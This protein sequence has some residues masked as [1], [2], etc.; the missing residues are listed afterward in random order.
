MWMTEGEI[1]RSFKFAKDQYYQ[2]TILS[3]LNATT[4]KEIKKILIANGFEIPTRKLKGV[5]LHNHDYTEKDCETIRE[6]RSNHK[7]WEQIAN[8]LGVKCS[9]SVRGF[10][11]RHG[12]I[13]VEETA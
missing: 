3:Q 10:A 5:K 2:I 6:M 7:S 9:N 4:R 1:C 11:V 13:K 8:A 12:I